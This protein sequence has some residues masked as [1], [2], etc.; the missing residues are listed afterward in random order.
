MEEVNKNRNSEQGS[1]YLKLILTI[2]LLYSVAHAGYNYIPVAYEAEN[3]K[4]DMQT[5]VVQ[6]VAMPGANLTIKDTVKRKIKLAAGNNNVPPEAVIDIK[7][8]GDTV[9]AH[10]VYTKKVEILP[11]GL[12]KYDYHFDNTATPTGFLF[13]E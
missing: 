3:F 2:L 12:Y 6:A 5:A 1:A 7:Q 11:F 13:K 4:Q 9:Q 8:K 10:V